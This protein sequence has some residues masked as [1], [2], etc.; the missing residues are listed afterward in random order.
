MLWL[1]GELEIDPPRG[2][3]TI[4][5]DVIRATTSIATALAAG[6]DRVTPVP[7]VEEARKEAARDGEALLC[8]ERRGLPPHG[9]D[10]GNAPGDFQCGSVAGRALV[11]TTT[12]GTA[13]IEAV[14]A[15]GAG[16]L[17]LAC[18]RNAGAVAR[19]VAADA[20]AAGRGVAIVCAGR[21]GRVSMDDAWC[22]GH[23]V[24]RLV[25]TV[26]EAELTDG[27]RA[28]Q[29]LSARLGPPTVTG[30]AGTAAGRAL[31]AI[32]RSADLAACARLDDLEVVPVWRGGA[33]VGSRGGEDA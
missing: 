20:D 33:L 31:R 32:G 14:R 6:A 26:A 27:A 24:G 29:A 12:N 16:S 23:L 9:F 30:L 17:R 1:P 11:F 28:A 15:A 4:V 18:F 21:Q 5:I 13:A 2:C 10:L 8:G 7:T 22:A 19:R 25:Q 3:A